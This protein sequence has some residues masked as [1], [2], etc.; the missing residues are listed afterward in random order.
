MRASSLGRMHPR[1]PHALFD[2][3]VGDGELET[4]MSDGQEGVGYMSS[5]SLSSCFPSSQSLNLP[6]AKEAY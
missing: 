6:E 5:S 3:V 1:L 4:A 2:E